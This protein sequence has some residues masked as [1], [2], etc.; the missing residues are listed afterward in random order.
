M[1]FWE[2]QTRLVAAR[3]EPFE[4]QSQPPVPAH[5]LSKSAV[6]RAREE[7]EEVMQKCCN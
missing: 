7:E 6:M 3:F 4:L 5:G 1:Q 2:S